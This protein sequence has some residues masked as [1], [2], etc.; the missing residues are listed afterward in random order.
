LG[1]DGEEE[2]EAGQCGVHEPDAR[3]YVDATSKRDR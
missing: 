1:A 2:H 3:A